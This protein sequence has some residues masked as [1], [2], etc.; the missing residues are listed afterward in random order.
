L[1]QAQHDFQLDEVATKCDLKEIELKIEL[2]RAELKKDIKDIEV[3]ISE[4]K[5]EL[6]RWV[7]AA[8]F[9]QSALVI[10]VVLKAAKLL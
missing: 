10:G 2:V 5:A 3:K 4:T 8:G 1:A 9:L 6:I 7:V